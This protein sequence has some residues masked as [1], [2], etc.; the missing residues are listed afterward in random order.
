[1]ARPTSNRRIINKIM[2]K[3]IRFT[4][5]QYRKISDSY[6]KDYINRHCVPD[7]H[8]EDIVPINH[9]HGVNWW[10]PIIKL[11]VSNQKTLLTMTDDNII[12]I[13]TGMVFEISINNRWNEVLGMVM[14]SIISLTRSIP[15]SM[16]K[17]MRTGSVTIQKSRSHIFF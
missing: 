17:F 7:M 6:D 1:M 10:Q 16:Y 3:L 11:E 5:N 14:K 13:I 4:E 2:N 9:T 15:L 8:S 12:Q